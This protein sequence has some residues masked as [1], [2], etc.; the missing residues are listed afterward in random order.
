MERNLHIQQRNLRHKQCA[1]TV[2]WRCLYIVA[3]VRAGALVSAEIF[4]GRPFGADLL[5]G[6]VAARV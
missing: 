1:I 2:Q 5:R 6:L 3:A 4:K